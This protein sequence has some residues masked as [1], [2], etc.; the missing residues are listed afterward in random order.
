MKKILIIA[1]VVAATLGY[2]VTAK[3]DSVNATVPMTFTVQEAFGFTLSQYSHDFGSIKTGEGAETTI[4]IICRSNH[5][6]QWTMN[7]QAPEFTNGTGGTLPSDPGFTMSGWTDKPGEPGEAQGEWL[8]KTGPIPSVAG[9]YDFYRST[10]A[11]G[12]DPFTALTIGLYVKL[13][14]AL[15][16]GLY[17]TSVNFTMTD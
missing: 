15:A 14:T 7:I 4:G 9:G 1:L 13:P 10:P 2:A 6:R 16:A 12:G 8:Y 11:E 5:G 3:A 17:S